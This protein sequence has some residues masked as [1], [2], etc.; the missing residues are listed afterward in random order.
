[1]RDKARIK[2]I[3]K[4]L[5]KLWMENSDQRLGQILENYIFVKGDRGDR[6]SVAMFYQEDD[7]TEVLL[8]LRQEI[9]EMI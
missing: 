7:E 2:R 3:L 4:M 8:K 5:E 6:T 9:A 1:M